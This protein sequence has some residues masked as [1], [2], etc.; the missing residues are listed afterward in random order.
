MPGA[1]VWAACREHGGG[2][3]SETWQGH[4]VTGL[5]GIPNVAMFELGL[6]KITHRV[7]QGEEQ[8]GGQAF[9]GGNAVHQL[10]E[11]GDK[12]CQWSSG[13]GQDAAAGRISL[14]PGALETRGAETD[15]P[16]AQRQE[17]PLD[18]ASVPRV[19]QNN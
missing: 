14:A 4:R 11:T 9:Q 10:P 18:I 3:S 1:E 7:S 5:Q 2:D 19:N 6:E 13:W 15:S 16:V 8:K 12:D 17:R